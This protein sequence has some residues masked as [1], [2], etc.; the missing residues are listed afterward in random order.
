MKRTKSLTKILGVL[1]LMLVLFSCENEM[2]KYY[3]SPDWL[4]GSAWDVLEKRG[5]FS[6]FLEGASQSGFESLL[7]GKG[8]VTVMAPTDSAFAQ[9]ITKHGKANIADF[10]VEELQKLIGFHIIYFSYSKEMLE[11]FRPYEGDAATDTELKQMAGMYYKHRTRSTDPIS[12]VT[13]E[14]PENPEGEQEFSVWHNDRM[15]PVFSHNIFKTKGNIDAAYNYEYFYPDSKWTGDDGFNVSNASVTEYEIPGDNGYIYV[16]NDVLE[17]LET[18]YTEIA[19]RENFSTYLE[20]YDRFA[21]LSFDEDLTIEFGGGTDL[22]QLNHRYLANIANEWPVSDFRNNAALS[23][24]AYGIYAPA[25]DIIDDFFQTYWAQGGYE[26][27]DSVRDDA[28]LQMLKSSI[29]A[30]SVLFPEEI[31]SGELVST[32]NTPVDFAVDNVLQENRKMCLNGTFYGIT[33]DWEIP[34]T[35]T[36]V[37]GPALQYKSNSYYLN[38]LTNTS[39]IMP[40]SSDRVPFTLLIPDD[41]QLEN[42]G[43]TMDEEDD[44]MNNWSGELESMS[45]AEMTE[46]IKLHTVTGGSGITGANDSYVLKTDIPY[47]YWYIKNNQLTTSISQS[48]EINATQE[49][50]AYAD[51]TEIKYNGGEWSNGQAFAYA[52]PSG[53]IFRSWTDENS[54]SVQRLIAISNEPSRPYYMFSQ[55]LRDAGLIDNELVTIPFLKE[56]RTLIFIPTNEVVETAI[57]NG[58]IPGLSTDGTVEDQSLLAAYMKQYFVPTGSNGIA[59]YPYIGSGVAGQYSTALGNRIGIVDDGSSLSLDLGYKMVN[60][61]GSNDYFPFAFNDGGVHFI[62]DVF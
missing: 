59:D 37:A 47:V 48:V 36:S 2:D 61:D 35:F 15:L 24:G 10:S 60:V 39:K 7:K 54:S 25:N 30:S 28:I 11:N 21:T 43:V 14:D 18:I 9:Y 4:K 41:T 12:L 6:I 26:S 50:A 33:T 44:L 62:T 20:L 34:S 53:G 51:I 56:S 19:E 32:A 40:L 5:D 55:L 23:Y 8:L 46:L 49:T 57:S 1:M 17:P 22:Y 45:I 58:L 38:M 52:I 29:Y 3:E 13:D 27:I 16:V 42:S 31:S